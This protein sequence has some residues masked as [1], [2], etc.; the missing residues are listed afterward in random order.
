MPRMFK[1]IRRR[2]RRFFYLSMLY[3]NLKV[4]YETL[5][6]MHTYLHYSLD[7]IYNMYPYERE[8]FMLMYK[9]DKEKE[10]KALEEHKRGLHG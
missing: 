6:V 1:R 2:A 9:N 4:F 5:H 3:T 7:D 8:I 10:R